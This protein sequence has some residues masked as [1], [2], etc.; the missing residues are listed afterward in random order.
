MHAYLHTNRPIK[1]ILLLLLLW[2]L[3]LMCTYF[4]IHIIIYS[5]R[6]ISQPLSSTSPPPTPNP[7]SS[8]R[9]YRSSAV[10]IHFGFFS[11]LGFTTGRVVIGGYIM[12][13]SYKKTGN[14]NTA[15]LLYCRQ[16]IGTL[17]IEFSFYY[18]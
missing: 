14:A 16:T 9:V 17:N 3:L 12:V 10:Y 5:H 2:S 6:S 4:I 18:Y 13:R 8:A 11:F 15:L 7:S 1:Y